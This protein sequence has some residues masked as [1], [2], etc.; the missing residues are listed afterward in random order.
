MGEGT[1]KVFMLIFMAMLVFGLSS[2]FLFFGASNPSQKYGKIKF[3]Y[4]NVNNIWVTKIKNKEAAFSFLPSD[5]SS[6]IIEGSPIALLKDKIE[7]DVTS[8]LNDSY[9]EGIALAQY[10]LGTVLFNYDIFVRQGFISNNLSNL[11]E[12]QYIGCDN[13]TQ[14]IPIIYFL[15]SNISKISESK[16]C[17]IAEVVSDTDA[18]RV[19]DR[20]VYGIFEVIVG[21]NK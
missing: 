19:K 10:Q 12:V 7:I 17:V 15:E 8:A 5:T 16:N 18:I 13:A 2:S 20:I 11:S 1:K 3:N 21:E 6:V 4:D 9:R 14:Q